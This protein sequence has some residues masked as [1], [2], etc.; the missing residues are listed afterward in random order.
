VSI[1]AQRA[2]QGLAWWLPHAA[3]TAGTS[4][5]RHLGGMSL[6]AWRAA[7]AVLSGRMAL[8]DLVSQMSSIGVQSVPLVTVIAAL[9]GIVSAQQGGYQI[10]SAIPP[11]V[12]GSAVTSSV[13]LELAPLMT[14]I[15][16][17]GRVGA[18]ITAELAT[19]KVSE[20]IDALY[21]L[22]RD[23]VDVLAAPRIAAGMLTTPLLVLWAAA[24]G[25][26]SGLVAAEL[27]AGVGRATFLYG[28]RLTWHSYDLFYG[29]VKGVAFG[30][31][32]PLISAH[33]GLLSSEGAEGVGRS[34]TA[35]VVT[36][37]IAVFFSDAL[38]PPLLLD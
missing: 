38:F 36:M 24:V 18:R 14:A 16:L 7:W 10:A 6:L 12:L 15:G 13:V 2:P 4:V 37:I 17:I 29:S 11:Y 26:L 27:A 23:P 20:Q 28:A 22:G 31:L 5:L 35:A 9:S 3:A 34:T 33:M 25:V 19:M 8:R 30:F 1:A 21:A 32:I